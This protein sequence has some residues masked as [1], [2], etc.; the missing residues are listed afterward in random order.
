MQ[1][2]NEMTLSKFME[3]QKNRSFG[4]ITAFRDT[5][6]VNDKVI[7]NTT[8][9]KRQLNRQLIS[10]LRAR[11]YDTSIRFRGTYI[12]N[13]GT[14]N[15]K[16]VKEDVILVL[17][18][19]K[20]E[21]EPIEETSER[22][23]KDLMNLGEKYNQDSILFKPYNDP[24]AYLIGTSKTCEFPEYHDEIS[25]GRFHPKAIGEFYSRMRKTPFVFSHELD[26]PALKAK[27]DQQHKELLGLNVLESVE[28]I[29]LK[30]LDRKQNVMLGAFSNNF[31]LTL[32]Q[33]QKRNIDNEI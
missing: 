16:E 24:F 13:Y 31:N 20:N 25:V 33:L 32:E 22:L 23:K 28:V 12:E 14:E 11:G 30:K 6:T 7:T 10:D 27:R 8:E 17:S 15:E 9:Y 21:E 1:I 19:A 4:C 5:R 26:V 29:A 2:L 3:L 18:V